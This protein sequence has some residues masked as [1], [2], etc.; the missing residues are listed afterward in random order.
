M[1]SIQPDGLRHLFHYDQEPESS[2]GDTQAGNLW[3]G[4]R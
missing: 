3:N 4:R 1:E 2:F